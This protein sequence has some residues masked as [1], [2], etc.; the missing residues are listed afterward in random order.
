MPHRIVTCIAMAV[1]LSTAVVL[2]GQST[3][4]KATGGQVVGATD[5]RRP[6]RHARRVGEQQHDAAP[7][8]AAV[9]RPRNDD[10]RG[11]GRPEA[12]G[13]GA[14]GRRRRVLRRRTDPGGA[15]RQNE[16]QLRRYTGRATTTRAG[17]P[18]ASSTIARRSSSTRRMAASRRSRRVQPSGPARCRRRSRHAAR[19]IARRICPSGHA[20]RQRRH[21]QHSGRL[22]ELLRDHAGSGRGGVPH[23]DDSRRAHLPDRR[24]RTCRAPSPSITATRARTGTATRSW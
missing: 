7:A 2:D 15:R 16:V 22:S 8:P 10:R 12:E 5:A 18:S 11:V 17:C 20:L 23:R 4:A 21:A 13:Q 6:P 1:A 3:S 19:P 24:R 14:D 9:R